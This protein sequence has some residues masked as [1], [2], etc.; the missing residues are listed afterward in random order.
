MKSHKVTVILY[1]GED[2]AYVSYVPLVP[3]M[4]D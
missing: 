4:Y 3:G 2:G 1:P